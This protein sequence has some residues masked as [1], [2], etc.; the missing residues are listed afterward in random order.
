MRVNAILS[1]KNITPYTNDPQA[2]KV[3]QILTVE[4]LRGT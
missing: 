4:G 2:L 3:S 1:N